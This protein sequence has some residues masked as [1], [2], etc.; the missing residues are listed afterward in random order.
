MTKFKRLIGTLIW[1]TK[2]AL[3]I[4]LGKFAPI[5]FGWMIG[6]KGVRVDKKREE[7]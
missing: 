4:S 3:G 7:Q 6:A 5:V 1:N 2:E